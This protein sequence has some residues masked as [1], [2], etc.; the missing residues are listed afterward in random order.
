MI[1]PGAE[2][3]DFTLKDQ[4]NQPVTLSSYRG[5]KNVLLVFFPLAFTGICQGELD[6]IRDNLPLYENDTTATLAISVGPSPTHKIWATQS[7][8]T[9]PVLSD[10]WPH[11]AVAQA[12]G[13]FNE[14]AGVSNRGTFVVDRTGI[15]RFAEMKQPGEVR[16]QAVWREALAALQ[17]G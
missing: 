10:F 11:G 12:Y 17:A 8:F 1:E 14:T 13:V 4:N 3:P 5:A 15:V 16:D 7:G 9:F 6:E 2:A